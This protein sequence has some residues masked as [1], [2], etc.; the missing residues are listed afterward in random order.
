MS[1]PLR[2]V[3]QK[4]RKSSLLNLLKLSLH[5]ANIR[6]Q[7]QFQA[8][9]KVDLVGWINTLEFK[10]IAHLFTERS[11]ALLPNFRHEKQCRADIKAV[12]ILHDLIAAST[13]AVVLFQHG[14]IVA[15]FSKPGRGGDSANS[16]ADH[17]SSL[18]VHL[19]P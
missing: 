15:V 5:F 3:I 16:S 2:N 17:N 6:G 13:W 19:S 4:T 9:V 10:M 18:F 14:Y 8:I 7:L 1:I 11:K 12:A